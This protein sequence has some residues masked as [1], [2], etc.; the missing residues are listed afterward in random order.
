MNRP[1]VCGAQLAELSRESRPMTDA[2]RTALGD[3]IRWVGDELGLRDWTIVLCDEPCAD[4]AAADVPLTAEKKR[5]RIRLC[6]GFRGLPPHEQRYTVVH[7]LLHC[8]QSVILALVGNDLAEH[9]N[10][11]VHDLFLAAFTRANEYATDGVASA[12][13]GHFPLIEWPTVEVS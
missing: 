12:I 7:E 4:G 9:L 8:H 5:A 6:P 10:S 1:V 2:E 11:S 3:Y 13:A